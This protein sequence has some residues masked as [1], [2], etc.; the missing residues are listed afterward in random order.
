NMDAE[1]MYQLQG[2]KPIGELEDISTKAYDAGCRDPLF[3]ACRMIVMDDERWPAA[4]VGPPLEQATK[5]MSE[6]HYPVPVAALAQHRVFK[7]AA[8]S[9]PEQGNVAWDKY[10]EL[11][12]ETIAFWKYHDLD[13]RV[14]LSEIWTNLDA[15]GLDRQKQFM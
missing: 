8:R 12:V 6:S 10:A 11:A 15:D 1:Q 3:I 14:I 4:T 9:D 13:R 7:I 5:Q 2:V